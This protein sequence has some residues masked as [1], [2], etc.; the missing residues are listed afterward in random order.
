MARSC[1]LSIAVTAVTVALLC[2]VHVSGSYATCMCANA[3]LCE[4]L[5]SPPVSPR[6]LFVFTQS[7]TGYQHYNWTYITTI[8]AFFPLET[9]PALLCEAHARGVRVVTKAGYFPV[10]NLSSAA[11]RDA[12]VSAQVARATAVG[13]DGVNVDIEEPVAGVTAA[14]QLTAMV[15]ALHDA[16]RARNPHAQ[17]TFDVAWGPDDVDGRAYDYAGLAAATDALFVMGYDERSQ[18]WGDGPCVAGANAGL[19]QTES[20]WKGY[21]Q[22]G[23]SATHLLAGMPWYGRVYPCLSLVNNVCTVREVP[24]RGCNCSDAV[25]SERGYSDIHPPAGAL[26]WDAASA[27]PFFNVGD[28]QQ[29][30]YDNPQSLVLKYAAAR[31]NGMRG[32]GMWTGDFSTSQAM[33]AAFDAFFAP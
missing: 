2:F 23:I 28:T 3:T 1:A 27:S 29:V 18:V 10:A 9:Y 13:A 15:G 30:W 4:P 5:K 33:W 32:V 25:S 12:W 22:L 7:P 24:F 6:E 31:A 21:A 8:A 26:Q 17:V 14:G 16:M 11:D 19:G 20:G